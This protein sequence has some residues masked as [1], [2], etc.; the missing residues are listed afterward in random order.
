M[1]PNNLDDGHAH[2]RVLQRLDAMANA[3]DQLIAAAHVGNKVAGR[4]AAVVGCAIRG[5]PGAWS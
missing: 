3:H 1:R 2:I 4:G 5:L